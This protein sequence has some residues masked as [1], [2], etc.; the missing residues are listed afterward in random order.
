MRHC[1]LLKMREV[2]YKSEASA[3]VRSAAYSGLTSDTAQVP[4]N[5]RH[6]RQLPDEEAVSARMKVTVRGIPRSALNCHAIALI[7]LSASGFARSR[8]LRIASSTRVS[9]CLV[10]RTSA[11]AASARNSTA[12]SRSSAASTR[13][14]ACFRARDASCSLHS[15]S[16][17]SSRRARSAAS[18]RISASFS[19][20]KALLH[21]DCARAS[22]SR[23]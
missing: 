10:S 13:D 8:R 3:N 21:S 23:A 2:T 20:S 14:W 11:S 7:L 22:V 6:R 17:M 12:V 4:N 9:A 19:L 16:V 15:A 18:V 5:R 1:R